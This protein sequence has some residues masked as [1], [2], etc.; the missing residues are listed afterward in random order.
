M[1]AQ[2]SWG[3][4][5]RNP[6]CCAGATALVLSVAICVLAP[7]AGASDG[8]NPF[9]ERDERRARERP[10][11]PD[12]QPDAPPQLQPFDGQRPWRDAPATPGQSYGAPPPGY[13][14][15]SGRGDPQDGAAPPATGRFGAQPPGFQDAPQPGA[16]AASVERVDLTPIA[17]LPGAVSGPE[18]AR[19]VG[20]GFGARGAGGQGIAS[21][22][23]PE[24]WRGLDAAETAE[25]I[26]PL[27]LPPRS[28][29]LHGLWVRLMT[30][31]AGGGDRRLDALRLEA[32]TRSGLL[33]A[34][35]AI[36]ANA[37]SAGVDPAAAA[38]AARLE[39]LVGDREAG[40]QRVKDLAADKAALP[41]PLKGE[42]VVL[43]GYCAVA[44]GN[45]AAAG[46]AA[47]L[48]REERYD[49]AFTLTLLETI[50]AGG[51]VSPRQLPKR[52]TPLDWRL[53]EIAGGLKPGDVFERADPALLGVLAEPRDGPGDARL[54]VVAAEAAARLNILSPAALAARYRAADVGEGDPLAGERDPLL[55]RARLFRAAERER[56]PSRVTRLARALIDDARRNGLLLHALAMLDQVVD[57][58]PREPEIGWFAETA[59]EVM[60]AA[61]QYEK[62]RAWAIFAG[63]VDR[64][65]G[66]TLQ[67]WRALIDIADPQRASTARGQSLSSVEELALRGR[68]N[69][70]MLHRLA[71]VL[72]ALDYNVPIPLWEAASRTPQ[73]NTGH[74]PATGVLP[75]LAEAAKTRAQGRVVLLAMQ[76]LG[77]TGAEGAHIIALGDAIRA[78][79]RAGF[80]TEARRLGLEALFAGWP[81][82]VS[83]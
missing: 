42:A 16:G 51:K 14:D 3:T 78:L 28:P 19:P 69:A 37:S 18:V 57:R 50:A 71:T 35:R 58:L 43:A 47:E 34:A 40:C 79:K 7:S 4:M 54:T 26:R 23:A 22:G 74:L 45:K 13:S 10:R 52:L 20:A 39:V 64:S 33:Q 77:T 46:L 70:D 81:R 27:D 25:L 24:M 38:V 56:T 32:L 80:E 29:A 65:G 9:R 73:P 67:H 31:D 21:G 68:F 6:A 17:P 63:A 76:T 11:Q 83:H 82:T 75:K 55:Q 60:L 30:S 1:G 53:A 8:W 48:A 61:G 5:R 66:G 41:Q 12:A 72:D 15:G 44:A 2:M 62:A 49:G 36:A 59:I